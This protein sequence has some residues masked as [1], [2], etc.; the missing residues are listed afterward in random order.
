MRE[1]DAGVA[2]ALNVAGVESKVAFAESNGIT[3][4]TVDAIKKDV[5]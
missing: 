3:V 5:W 1:R 2:I 4:I